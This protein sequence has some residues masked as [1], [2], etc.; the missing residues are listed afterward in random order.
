MSRPPSL[1]PAQMRWI[2]DH[3]D[4]FPAAIR[5]DP[6]FPPPEASRHVIRAYQIR[7]KDEKSD[8]IVKSETI[9]DNETEFLI[10]TIHKY[11]SR[12][13][14]PGRFST[15]NGIIGYIQYLKTNPDR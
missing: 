10:D 15:R 14:L 13:G 6:G 4:M 9:H 2:D 1:T 3:P 11:I 7:S 12:Y 8:L 5:D